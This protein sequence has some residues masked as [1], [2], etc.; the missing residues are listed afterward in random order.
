MGNQTW[1]AL[2]KAVAAKSS[3]TS[4]RVKVTTEAL[5]IRAGA[6][7]NYNIVG[8]IR[9]KG[10]YTIVEEKAGWGRL[11]SGVGWICLEFTKKV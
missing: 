8:C 6:G 4:Y 2:D 3:T 5:N 10:V 7:T 11:K 9:D 1:T